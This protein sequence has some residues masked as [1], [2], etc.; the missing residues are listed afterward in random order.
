MG[1]FIAICL[2]LGLAA[3][4]GLRVFVPLFAVSVAMK[5]GFMTGDAPI[6][7][8]PAFQWMGSN[9]AVALFGV[10]AVVELVGY[11]FRWVDH[12]LDILAVPLAA[13]A[14]ALLL[15]SQLT[16]LALVPGADGADP[17]LVPLMHPALAWGVGIVVGALIAIGVEAAS[18][19]GRLSSSVLTIGWLNP[20][21]GMVESVLALA[22]TLLTIFV[23]Q[24][25]G[26]VVMLFVPILLLAAWRFFAWR[27]KQRRAR[28]QKLLAARER[29]AKSMARHSHKL[30]GDSPAA[31]DSAA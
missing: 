16:A 5:W 26:I 15:T 10:A 30:A 18:I 1:L 11:L 6:Q 25:V 24:L 21:Y 2:G 31:G 22:I 3:A 13:G 23:P 17:T 8:A 4:C 19:V 27:S 7:A 12:L 9:A 14:G 20:L 28:E 29:I